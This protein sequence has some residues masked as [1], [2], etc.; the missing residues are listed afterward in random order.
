M[1]K[2]FDCAATGYF[3]PK[4]HEIYKEVCDREHL[5]F[6][7][8]SIYEN[9]RYAKQSLEFVRKRILSFIGGFESDKLVFTSGGSESNNL[10]IKGWAFQKNKEGIPA[11]IYLSPVEHPSVIN[12]V[13]WLYENGF[14]EG[15][16]FIPF[17]EKKGVRRYR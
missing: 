8:S 17:D 9:S 10:A 7:P 14:I 4:M 11:Y 2:Y 12:T 1:I 13:D 16:T 15:Y 5:N 6:N 3:S